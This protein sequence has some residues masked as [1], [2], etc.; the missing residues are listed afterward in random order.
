MGGSDV[1][2]A[3]GRVGRCNRSVEGGSGGGRGSAADGG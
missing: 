1:S 3:F 2:P